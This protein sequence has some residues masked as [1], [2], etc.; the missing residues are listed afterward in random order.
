MN[1]IKNNS[2]NKIQSPIIM[3][4][5][6]LLLNKCKLLEIIRY[7]KALQ[8][9]LFIRKYNYQKEYSKI[10]IEITPKENIYDVFINNNNN[11]K[12]YHIF[13]NNKFEEEI[14]RN[15]INKTDEVSKIKIIIDD[16]IKS[17]KGLFN[18][19]KCIKYINFI[20][21]NRK[22]IIN[23]GDMFCGCSNLEKINLSNF[24]TNKVT[25]MSYMF[26]N[27][28]LLTELNLSTFNTKNVT[29]MSYMFSECSSLKNI[30][31]SSFNTY[32]VVEMTNMFSRC[33]GLT[34]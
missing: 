32:N 2:C 26:F 15:R 14:K 34:K 31:L 21:F 18:Q 24:K 5:I 4:K 1:D 20:R 16:K 27:C 17:F 10:I 19:C 28:S 8:N 6:F 23:M 12:S 7:N 33:S 9:M 13:F 25:D 11:Y 22:N 29:D 30:N 3:K